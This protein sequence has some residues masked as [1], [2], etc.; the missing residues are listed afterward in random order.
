M[1]IHGS[2]FGGTVINFSGRSSL[3][4]AFGERPRNRSRSVHCGNFDGVSEDG[5]SFVGHKCWRSKMMK[6][7]IILESEITESVGHA[8]N[9]LLLTS[10]LNA[11]KLEEGI[12]SLGR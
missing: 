7:N 3:R 4:R 10:T 1:D 5:I 11:G 12:M 9:K 8:L 6:N 2:N